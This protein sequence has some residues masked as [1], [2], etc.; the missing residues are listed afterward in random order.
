MLAKCR[1]PLVLMLAMDS[2][3][4]LRKWACRRMVVNGLGIILFQY[5]D[6]LHEKGYR[7]STIQLY[8]QAVEHFGF[9]RAKQ[10]PKSRSVK[11]AEVAEFLNRHLSRCDC[12][13]PAATGF[14]TCQ[15]ALNRL[16]TM[17]GC[18]NPSSQSCKGERP[19]ATVVAGFDRHLEKVCGLSAATRFYRRRYAQEFLAW[20]FEG[21]RWDLTKLCFADF[22][23]YVKFRAPRLK[24]ASLAVMLTS[25]RSLI[26]FLEFEGKCRPGLSR[27]WP[28]MPNWKQSPPSNILTTK[29]C[30]D[31]LQSVD[32]HSPSG[33]RDFAILR[34]M[35]D[36]GLRGAEIVELCIEDIDW[37]AGTLAIRKNKQRRERLLPLPPLVAK[38][39]LSYLRTSR[40][41]SSSRRLFLCHRLPVGQP[42]NRERV[43]GAV[44]RIMAQNGLTAG[45][46]HRLRHSFAT[47]LH[48][49]GASLKE[50]ADVMG[51][52]HFDTTAIYARVNL[53]QLRKVALAWPSS[54][55]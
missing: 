8:T 9:W 44:R 6:W 2:S 47:R 26:R 12:P 36:L 33:Q 14:Q 49:R 11:A 20:R 29:E 40:P 7:R 37:R 16:M 27:A 4:F 48:A 3:L 38:A 10:H 23:A 31:L 42:M 1:E 32:R 55:L 25:L 5:A 51:H 30:R 45:G 53:S 50:V 28:T 34:L 18:S 15:S 17:I 19:I 21:K 46:P 43:R 13:T 35:T 24:P 52:Q 39:I 22:V 54:R 41:S